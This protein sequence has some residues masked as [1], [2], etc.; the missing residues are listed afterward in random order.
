MSTVTENGSA[1]INRQ[2]ELIVLPIVLIISLGY[3][4]WRITFPTTSEV[5]V[6]EKVV[7]T[8]VAV[9]SVKLFTGDTMKVDRAV[10]DGLSPLTT[11]VVEDRWLHEPVFK[12]VAD[13]SS[14]EG[15]RCWNAP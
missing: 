3:V 15:Y 11:Y 10:Y 12:G 1:R 4:V 14:Q 8:N 5:T 6:C 7:S 13:E 2:I 9:K